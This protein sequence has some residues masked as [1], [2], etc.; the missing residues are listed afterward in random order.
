VPLSPFHPR[1]EERRLEG[2]QKDAYWWSGLEESNLR[3]QLGS[4]RSAIKL[5]PLESPG[6]RHLLTLRLDDPSTRTGNLRLCWS[7]ALPIP[8]SFTSNKRTRF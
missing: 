4:C 1:L 7:V 2:N 5:R 8:S 6:G 3:L